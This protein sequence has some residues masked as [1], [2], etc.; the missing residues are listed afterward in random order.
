MVRCVKQSWFDEERYIYIHFRKE[1]NA[2]EDFTQSHLERQNILNN[3][4]AIK[5]AKEKI[6]IPGYIYNDVYYYT[7]DQIASFF[8]VTT[9]TI[10]RIIET[11]KEELLSNGYTILKGKKLQEFKETAVLSGTDINVGTKTTILSV[12][13]FRAL[14]NIAMLLSNSNIA[15]QVRSTILDIAINLL[16]EKTGGNTN[17]INQLD[18]TYLSNAFIEETE[19]EKFTYAIDKFVEGNHFK[20]ANLTNHIYKV[21]FKENAK[22]Y[23]EVLKLN[24]NH[25]V[26]ETM[27]S[28]VLLVIASFEKGLAYELEKKFNE[29]GQKLSYKEAKEVIDIFA[30]HPLHEP[31]LNDVRTKMASR[32]LGFRDVIHLNLEEYIS[33]ITEDDFEKFLGD[34]SKSLEKQIQ[35]H[36]EV[37]LRLKDK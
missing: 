26:R 8:D 9:R 6:R 27:Y 7:N 5:I 16:A 28:E 30:A 4:K 2:M 25:K 10:E 11:N 23:R 13:N 32:D 35:E 3:S 33:P 24:K 1:N 31:H 17:Y 21:I 37:F 18:K 29:L 34:Q 12:F 15:K 19:R 36:K 22:E 20:F 14:L